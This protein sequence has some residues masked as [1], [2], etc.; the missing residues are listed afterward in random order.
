MA[1]VIFDFDSTLITLES[2]EAI[3]AEQ[4]AARPAL[5]EEITAVT[6]MGMEGLID[7]AESLERRLAIAAPSRADVAGFAEGNLH[8]ITPGMSELVTELID[9][10]V[11]VRIVSGGLHEAIVPFARHLGLAEDRVHAVRLLWH[12]DGT[13]AGIDRNDPFS[14]SKPAGVAPLVAAWPEPRIAIGD[15]MTDYHLFRDSLVDAFIAYTG[16]VAREAVVALG[17][18]VAS[19]TDTLRKHLEQR[20]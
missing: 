4:L 1:T 5:M 13:F 8:L 18:P 3:L 15:G 14:I 2:L 12:E 20:L 6:N 9:R 16:N 10:G 19:D 11:E 17:T 7:F